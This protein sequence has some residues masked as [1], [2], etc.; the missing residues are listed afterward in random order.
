MAVDHSVLDFS[1][2]TDRS[3][4]RP[5]LCHQH[6]GIM[7]H[8]PFQV[9]ES[10]LAVHPCLQPFTA[11]GVV[12]TPTF[13]GVIF[14]RI[15]KV[16]LDDATSQDFF[17]MIGSMERIVPC[18]G[19]VAHPKIKLGGLRCRTRRWSGHLGGRRSKK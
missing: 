19:P 4:D 15:M 8:T 18:Q 5:F 10:T 17:N 3:W 11:V 14:I 1:G 2:L 9:D 16:F 12:R 7:L 13:P 6:H